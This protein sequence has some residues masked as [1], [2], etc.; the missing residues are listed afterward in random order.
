MDGVQGLSLELE[1]EGRCEGTVPEGPGPEAPL[2]GSEKAP[3]AASF[4]SRR[5]RHAG[6]GW[7]QSEAAGRPPAGPQLRPRREAAGRSPCRPGSGLAVKPRGAA[8]RPGSGLAVTLVDVVFHE[9]HHLLELVLQ[10]RPP[11]RGVRLQGAHDLGRWRGVVGSGASSGR[12]TPPPRSHHTS[13]GS[14]HTWPGFPVL[15]ATPT[16]QSDVLGPGV[17]EP[18]AHAR[19]P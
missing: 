4:P 3:G 11:G 12:R 1:S 15:A 6:R 8:R 5:G 14:T 17:P 10:L 13:G 19:F 9:G 2:P 7:G 18:R 16:A